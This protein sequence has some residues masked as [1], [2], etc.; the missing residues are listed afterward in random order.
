MPKTNVKPAPEVVSQQS[1]AA[2]QLGRARVAQLRR[3]IN[4]LERKV[5]ATEALVISQL[6]GGAPVQEGELLPF[7]DLKEGACRPSWKELHL[8]HMAE[9][10]VP[11]AAVEA[12]AQDAYPP[13]ITTVLT[14]NVRPVM[15]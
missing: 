10:G 13:K 2:I 9:H 14:I 5:E 8:L 12:M 1:L 15:R 6:H 11:A 4:A 3:E 7:V